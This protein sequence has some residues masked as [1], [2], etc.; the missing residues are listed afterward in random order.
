MKL[1]EGVSFEKAT[2]MLIEMWNKVEPPEPGKAMAEEVEACW[3]GDDNGVW[4]FSVCWLFC[5][6]NSGGIRYERFKPGVLD[7]WDKLFDIPYQSFLDFQDAMDK[8]EDPKDTKTTEEKY[9]HR[10]RDEYRGKMEDFT[11]VDKCIRN[12]VLFSILHGGDKP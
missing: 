12:F 5:Y 4:D 1:K 10:R 8:I 3:H 9:L 7:L 2:E 6:G 11:F